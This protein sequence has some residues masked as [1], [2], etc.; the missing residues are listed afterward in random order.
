MIEKELPQIDLPEEWIAG[1]DISKE[2]LS[3]YK[4]F[5]VR[6]E[7]EIFVLCT[8][9]E[10]DAMV[11]LNKIKVK[12]NNVVT[13]MPGSILQ[14]NNIEGNLKIY[15]M[16]FS[17]KYIEKNKLSTSILDTLYLTL[18]RPVIN[19]R[20]QH[21]KIIED[22]FKF[23]SKLYEEMDEKIRPELTEN[24]YANFH[25]I[26]SISYKSKSKDSVNLSKSE[27]LGKQFTQLVM[28]YYK[29]NR[30]VSWYAEQIGITQAYLCTTIKQVSGH[31]CADIISS[32]VIMDAK[33]QLKLTKHSVQEIS[34]SLNFANMS[35][36][37][38]Y[39]KRYVG[40]SPLE[41]RNKG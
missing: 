16:G 6:L 31:T 3:L 2:L 10:V 27:Q 37:G 29:I 5:P 35:F 19:V 14:I 34:D 11:N 17:S 36:F 40:V 41:Y 13:L 30:N 23:I 24:L 8:D 20:E 33:S 38:K 39:F 32:M 1:K 9:G 12:A 28:Q 21:K 26:I 4:N 25:K 15:F 7:C 22:Y 18:G